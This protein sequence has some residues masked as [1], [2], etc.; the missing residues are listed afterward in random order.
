MGLDAFELVVLRRPADS[1]QYDDESR[2]TA[3]EAAQPR[4]SRGT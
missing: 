2:P 4:S 1:T 3:T